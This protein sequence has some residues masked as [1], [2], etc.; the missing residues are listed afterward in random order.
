MTD[1][2]P[3]PTP[4]DAPQQAD[5][6][7][8]RE[9]LG[10][11]PEAPPDPWQLVGTDFEG[12]ITVEAVVGV[13]GFGTVYRAF[14]RH[15]RAPVALKVLRCPDDLTP[16]Q[17][18]DLL[19]RFEQ[20]AVVLFRLSRLTLD[21]AACL[22]SGTFVSKSGDKT[23]YIV[24]EWLEGQ[25]LDELLRPA[26]KRASFG[27]DA[28]MAL[29]AGPVRA[30]GVA[31]DQGIVHR[32]IKPSNLFVVTREGQPQAK[33]LDFGI[34]KLLQQ[35]GLDGPGPAK[36]EG[37]RF[38]SVEY[39]APEQWDESLGV[40][41]PQTDLFSVALVLVEML[42]G[43]AALKGSTPNALMFSTM[44]PEQ[45]PT[46]RGRG[47]AIPDGVEALFAQALAVRPEDR[48]T[49][50]A[51]WWSELQNAARQHPE[52]A[53]LPPLVNESDEAPPRPSATAQ[54]DETPPPMV[55]LT[56]PETL[57]Q[58]ELK[59]VFDEDEAEPVRFAGRARRRKIGL[60]V[61]SLTVG[62]C[63]LFVGVLVL[64]NSRDDRA[65]SAISNVHSALNPGAVTFSAVTSNAINPAAF[66]PAPG[67]MPQP[68]ALAVP[69]LP[70]ATLQQAV[71]SPQETASTSE[72]R[73]PSNAAATIQLPVAAPIPSLE[74]SLP[75]EAPNT[76]KTAPD[77][78]AAV[79][80]EKVQSQRGKAGSGRLPP[81]TE[82]APA[83]A[84]F[85]PVGP[86]AVASPNPAP[87]S[88]ATQTGELRLN[89]I[90]PSAIVID[91]R[92]IGTT[93]KANVHLSPGSHNVTFV[94]PELGKRKLLV[95]VEPGKSQTL[96]VKF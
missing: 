55:G 88:P 43:K 61:T 85:A 18:Q 66:A 58:Q 10:C 87:A 35:D 13:G 41:S 48:P 82:K 73:A 46:P 72:F 4:A 74:T 6:G 68:N 28:A 20:E 56:G 8:H 37:F 69:S 80:S 9:S 36:T 22:A 81:A 77:L 11:A 95:L 59:A 52:W 70:E 32:D 16:S 64:V 40:P 39:A 30:L 42:C 12:G 75:A 1:E 47:A 3:S 31:H 25:S 27:L 62:A 5:T 29:L 50:L 63:T 94:H 51:A 71:V 26:A 21:V 93:P 19:Q 86:G 76:P 24:Q 53:S 79:D 34:A 15:F 67:N 78:Q 45:R 57:L 91:G 17:R 14:H 84:A 89:S 90:P 54:L 49:S 44:N 7:D 92:P 65:R 23:P 33:L 60:W 38:L 2:P 96:S 83:V